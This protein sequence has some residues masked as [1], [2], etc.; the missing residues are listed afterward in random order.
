MPYIVL[1][2]P[3]GAGKTTQIALLKKAL[4]AS[5]HPHVFTREPG[6]T[7]IGDE[8]RALLLEGK[9]DKMDAITEMF[10]LTASRHE[11]ARQVIRPALKKG[12]IVISDRCFLSTYVF[13]GYGG[14][15]DKEV[16]KTL[17]HIAMEETM[18]DLIL[19][20]DLT[21]EE[22]LRRKQ[23]QVE[24]GLKETRME[25]KG[26]AYHRRNYQGYMDYARENPETT[27]LIKA[28]DI[29]ENVHKAII[30]TLNTHF[31]LGLSPQS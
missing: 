1:E 12:E 29:A 10:I 22:G 8:L 2:G 4:A 5:Q 25:D 31:G 11:L 17:T 6:G 14:G 26:E 9:V 15:Q 3:D 20:L 27:A 7:P 13:Q 23:A 21:P 18:P 19:I 30:E 28:S 24:E 16:I